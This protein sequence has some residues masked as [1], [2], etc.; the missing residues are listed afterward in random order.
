MKENLIKY[1]KEYDNYGSKYLNYVELNY[2]LIDQ[3]KTA[4]YES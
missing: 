3:E 1:R 4:I 2:K